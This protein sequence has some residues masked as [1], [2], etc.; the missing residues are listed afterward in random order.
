MSA[1]NSSVGIDGGH[2]LESIKEMPEDYRRA[3][4]DTMMIAAQLE[5]SVLPWCYEVFPTCPDIGAK[6]AVAAAIQDEL[7]HAHQ[8][9]MMLEDFDQSPEDLIF[10]TSPNKFKVF[11]MLQIRLR[12][13]I[14]FVVAQALLDRSGRV[15]TL[16]LEEHCSYAPYRRALRKVNFEEKFHI[17]HGEHW[18]EY[19]WNLSAETR[20][21]V[22]EYVDWLFPH[23]LSWFGVTDARKT[24]T[25]Q[26]KY[27]IRGLSN[28]AMRQEW[29]KSVLQWTTPL[30]IVVPAHWD[31]EKNEIVLDLPF[32]MLC[33][34]TARRWSG[35]LATW[36][37][38][39]DQWKSGVPS[40]SEVIG[41]LQREEWGEDLWTT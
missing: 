7:G 27:R 39:V 11:Y 21:K 38:T 30:G 36:E 33:D 14:E 13:Y 5:L 24:R 17:S 41:R 37:D 18:T 3:L 2:I 26:L 19:Y 22:Q 28:D 10:R 15:T 25:A 32:P 31:D 20:A 23:G 8:M 40:Y 12:N 29:L 16:D 4:V 9:F 1:I 34:P 35:T 6:I